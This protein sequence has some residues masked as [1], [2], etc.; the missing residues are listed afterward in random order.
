MYLFFYIANNECPDDADKLENTSNMIQTFVTYVLSLLILTMNFNI[1]IN[2]I[3]YL[4][5]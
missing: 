1:N 2:I 3:L 5:N 4:N